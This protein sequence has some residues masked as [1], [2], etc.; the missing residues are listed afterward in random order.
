MIPE[1]PRSLGLLKVEAVR[2]IAPRWLANSDGHE[3]AWWIKF[4]DRDL[5]GFPGISDCASPA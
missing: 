1:G 2:L 4:Y 3:S 5:W